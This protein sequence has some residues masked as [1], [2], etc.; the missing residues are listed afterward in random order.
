MGWRTIFK[1]GIKNTFPIFIICTYPFSLPHLIFN[2]P[3]W[4]FAF[5]LTDDQRCS[6]SSY[7]QMGIVLF[8]AP[9]TST[10]FFSATIPHEIPLA[11]MA[12]GIL[13][14]IH[15]VKECSS[16]SSRTLEDERVNLTELCRPVS[17]LTR[18]NFLALVQIFRASAS[19]SS[20]DGYDSIYS[21]RA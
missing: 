14:R 19:A 5:S 6:G 12:P 18:Q 7:S 4:V 16:S 3:S 21:Y 15:F 11:I 2:D 13:A 10:I 1:F 20:A 17:I 8:K 9:D